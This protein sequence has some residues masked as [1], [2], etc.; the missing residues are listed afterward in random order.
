MNTIIYPISADKPEGPGLEHAAAVLAR[1]GI[2]GFPTE[3]VYG[4][5]VNAVH[6]AA[7]ERLQQVKGRPENK[8]FTFHLA[9]VE[10]LYRLIPHPPEACLRLARKFWP[11][12]LTIVFPTGGP[13]IGVRVPAHPVARSLIRKA[14]V[15]VVASSANRSGQPPATEASQVLMEFDGQ[16]EILIDSGP[17]R[18][19]E[20]S[21]V[22]RFTDEACWELVREGV[23]RPEMIAQTLDFSSQRDTA[24]GDPSPSDKSGRG[25]V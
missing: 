10:D 9:D 15:S 17:A 12:P 25:N 23:I 18:L 13:G 8:P 2:V 20:A 6:K 22:I 21:T 16:I 1:G 5:A 7:L 24:E 14:G 4:L 19:K 3:T 11:G